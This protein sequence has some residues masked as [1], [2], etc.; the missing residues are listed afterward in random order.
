VLADG[1][2]DAEAATELK[3]PVDWVKETSRSLPVAAAVTREQW[4]RYTSQGQKVRHLVDRA[5]TLV[6]AQ[7]EQNPA[8]ALDVLRAVKVMAPAAPALSPEELLRAECQLEA[9]TRIQRQVVEMGLHY[10]SREDVQRAAVA[11]FDAK[12]PTQLS[13][14]E[15]P[16][17]IGVS[18]REVS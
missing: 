2:S 6:G 18:G 3:V 15:D 12:A 7:L 5:L 13:A 10:V 8:M 17:E 14:P 11:L 4:R 9:E 16:P 1:A